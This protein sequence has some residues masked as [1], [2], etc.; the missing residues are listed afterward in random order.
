MKNVEELRV[1]VVEDEYYVRKGIIQSFDWEKLGCV[2]VG[3]AANGKAGIEVVEQC[4]PDLVIVDIEMPVMDG[5]EM[6]KRL[7][8]KRRLDVIFLTAHQKFTYVHSALKLE[9]VDYL[10]KP[11]RYEELEECIRRVRTK[12][13]KLD[14]EEEKDLLLTQKELQIKNGYIKDA[15]AYVRKHYAEEISNVT[16]AEKLD[17]NSAYF[18]RLFKKE[19]GYTF[20][21]YLT[22]YRIHVAAGLLTNFDMRIN[23]VAMQVG[24]PDSNY[25]SQ[26]FKK[27]MGMTPK[28]YQDAKKVF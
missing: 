8:S 21:Q 17:I 14:A 23:E 12:E 15:V 11:F 5:I 2:I 20:G 4:D 3:E 18:C 26:V 19:T 22:N 13:H 27:I 10:L 28:E 7:K 6:V 9:A 16:A 24:I 25:F 1:V